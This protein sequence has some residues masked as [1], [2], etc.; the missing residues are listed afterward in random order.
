MTRSAQLYRPLI[1]SLMAAGMIA[2]SGGS[3]DSASPTPI[4]P[5][6]EV[7]P[8][9]LVTGQISIQVQG[10]S[11]R[12]ISHSGVTDAAG[13]FE[14]RDGETVTFFLGDTD[15]ASVAGKTSI[16]PLDFA[17]QTELLTEA[18]DILDAIKGRDTSDYVRMFNIVR[19]LM[20]LDEDNDP[21]NGVVISDD[22]RTAFTDV[23]LNT[24]LGPRVFANAASGVIGGLD[25]IMMRGE[26]VIAHFYKALEQPILVDD[27]KRQYSVETDYAFDTDGDGVANNVST[28]SYDDIGN[29]MRWERRNESR[30]RIRVYSYNSAGYLARD[31]YDGHADG[32]ADEVEIYEYDAAGNKSRYEYDEEADGIMEEIE[33]F[34]YDDSGNLTRSEYDDDADGNADSRKTYSYDSNGNLT[35]Y[36]RDRDIDGIADSI[37]TYTYD[38]SGNRIRYEK[39]GDGD[40]I[41][42]SIETYAYN[43]NG[44]QTRIE[45]DGNGDGSAETI[46]TFTY[47]ENGNDTRYETDDDGDGIAD[48]IQTHT[49]DG[50]GNKTRTEYDNDGDN[51]TDNIETYV[52]A[53]D[54]NKTRSEFD[55]GADGSADHIFTYAYDENGNP[56]LKEYDFDADGDLDWVQSSSWTPGWIL[57]GR[58]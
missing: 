52:Y 54:G 39:H 48:S 35:R 15:L 14:Y 4:E 8:T 47:D 20:T 57:S 55:T 49:Y 38:D 40:G 22:S 28:W 9:K 7:A 12:T 17:P 50:N 30:A 36:E 53:E 37:E 58:F 29:R 10:L 13:G 27:G 33:T 42:D 51:I 2:C 11:Y 25:R 6:V 32:V 43:D 16:S 46:E 45:K 44:N 24:D 19:L 56:V 1:L 18:A 41:A 21:T 23:S 5:P 3:A 31:E 34:V 26:N